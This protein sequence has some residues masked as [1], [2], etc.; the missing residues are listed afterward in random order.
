MRSRPGLGQRLSEFAHRCFGALQQESS[1]L[2]QLKI[3][4]APFDEA[5]AQRFLEFGDPARQ[6]RL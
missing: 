4:R 3:A 1:R 2:R 5:D 6:G